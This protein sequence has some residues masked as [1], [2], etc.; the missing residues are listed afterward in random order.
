MEHAVCIFSAGATLKRHYPLFEA[1]SA[2]EYEKPKWR[3]PKVSE[4]GPSE[5]TR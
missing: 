2:T 5:E 3:Q 4:Y 1:H